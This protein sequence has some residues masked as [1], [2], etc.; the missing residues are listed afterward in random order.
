MVKRSVGRVLGLAS[1]VILGGLG[2]MQ[3][4][5]AATQTTGGVNWLDPLGYTKPAFYPLTL[6]TPGANQ[7]WVDLASG[8]GTSCTS[9][10][11]CSWSSVQG[12]PGTHGDGGGAY[13][14]IKNSGPIG[15]PTLY[16]TAGNEVVI[17]PWDDNTLATITGRN[18]WTGRVQYIV[19]DGGPNLKI[20]FTSTSNSQFDP[21]VYFNASGAGT[22]SHITFYRTQWTVPGMGEY[23]SQWGQVDN[24][25]I[26]NSEFQSGSSTDSG[27]QHHIYF[28]GA[29]NYGTSAHIDIRNNIF[30]DTPGETIEF[31]MFQTMDDVLIDGNAFHNMGKG[32]CSAS[33]KCRPAIT[34]AS[35]GASVT[36]IQIS[37]NLM[38]DLGE[39]AVRMWTGSPV[40]YNNTIW[41]WG[42]GSPANAGWGQWAFY[43]GGPNDGSGTLKNNIIYGTGTTQNGYAL[44][45]FD[46]SSGFTKSNNACASGST[47][48]CGQTFQ[49]S[50]TNQTVVSLSPSNAGFMVPN[51]SVSSL[52]Q[53]GL[54]LSSVPTSY[55]GTTRVAP[56]DI[57]A[58]TSTGGLLTLRAPTNLRIVR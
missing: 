41:Q 6:P 33:W 56:Y 58:L 16:G 25:S 20:K 32:T 37:N 45:P 35:S 49:P 29:S 34:I 30:R 11:P 4:L 46:N 40:V 54:T 36:N 42:Q 5:G 57:G 3:I 10:S 52:L 50:G 38:W 17:K 27:N 8:S 24:L 15:S 47:S 9:G 2:S 51:G 23:I 31:R 22:Q 55:S 14:Y 19:F 1:L 21:S 44:V 53:N 39:G 13:I 28:S 43:G 7:Y 26:I 18:N 12:K 48:G